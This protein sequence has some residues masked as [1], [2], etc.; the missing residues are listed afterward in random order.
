MAES[1]QQYKD[2]VLGLANRPVMKMLAETPRRIAKLVG[3]SS[4]ARLKRRPAPGK[5]SVG[6]ILAHLADDELV[7]GY[8]LRMIAGQPG[9]AL[10]GFDQDAWAKQMNYAARRPKAS[11]SD[12]LALRAI[13]VDLLKG[14][15]PGQWKNVG[16]HSE[17]GPESISVIAQ[18]AAGHDV[19]HLR[20]IES[21]LAK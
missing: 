16:L 1:A 10:Q 2:R 20:Q 15:K 14:L 21:I 17:R 7:I 8:R 5:W 3:A 6:E 11:L 18:L 19:L 12:Y 4:P 13:N 9:A